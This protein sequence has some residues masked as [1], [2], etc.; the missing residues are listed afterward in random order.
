VPFGHAG[1]RRC[2]ALWGAGRAPAEDV[3][4]LGDRIDMRLLACH[5][6]LPPLLL[7]GHHVPVERV[8]LRSA[9]LEVVAAAAAPWPPE[10]GA[11]G[12]VTRSRTPQ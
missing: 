2:G 9:L 1:V 6:A 12:V 7:K 4:A 11:H 8:D 10:R 3:D 5:A